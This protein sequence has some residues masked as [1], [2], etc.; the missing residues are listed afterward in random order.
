MLRNA[1]VDLNAELRGFA[2]VAIPAPICWLKLLP[3][4]S[5]KIRVVGF[6]DRLP[7]ESAP[8]ILSG[9]DIR[10]AVAPLHCI[11]RFSTS[12]RRSRAVYFSSFSVVLRQDRQIAL[13]KVL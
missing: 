7:G 3:A 11:L 6:P 9:K 1:E 4:G 2:N 8:R 10:S 5:G 12:C 13:P